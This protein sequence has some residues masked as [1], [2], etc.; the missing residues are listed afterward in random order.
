ME[1]INK[2]ST[3]YMY[4]HH[5]LE[6]YKFTF[7]MHFDQANDCVRNLINAVPHQRRINFIIVFF[8]K[9]LLTHKNLYLPYEVDSRNVN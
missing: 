9:L 4:Y 1:L 7:N 5:K 3:M 6:Y 2:M 8:V